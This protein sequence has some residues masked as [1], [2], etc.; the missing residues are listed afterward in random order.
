[1]KIPVLILNCDMDDP[2]AYA[3]GQIRTRVDA[4]IEMIEENKKQKQI[5]IL[6]GGTGQWQTIVK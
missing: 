2:R 6:S 5:Q 1:M 4:F 3:E